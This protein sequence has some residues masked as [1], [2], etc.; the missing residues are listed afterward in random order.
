VDTEREP[1]GVALQEASH[2]YSKAHAKS[3][4]QRHQRA[5]PFLES[6]I[7]YCVYINQ[8]E[9]ERARETVVECGRERDDV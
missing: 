9:R 7:C 1:P 2:E 8:R 6:C 3:K 4:G 5:V